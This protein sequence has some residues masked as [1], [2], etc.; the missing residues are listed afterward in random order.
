MGIAPEDS[1]P[2]RYPVA[3]TLLVIFL[4]AFAGAALKF[5]Q[6]KYFPAKAQ[7]YT[8][9]VFINETFAQFDSKFNLNNNMSE[10]QQDVL[11]NERYRYNIFN[12]TCKPLSCE[13]IIG[14]PTLKLVC[15]EEGFT[16]DVRIAM[17]EDCVDAAKKPM[18]TVMFQLLTR[19]TGEYYLGRSGKF[20]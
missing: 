4:I 13:K 7:E 3:G 8:V 10:A 1:W 9:P 20:V 15:K 14:K 5:A 18:V 2:K 12:W 17:D 11:F 19:T 16:E 6:M